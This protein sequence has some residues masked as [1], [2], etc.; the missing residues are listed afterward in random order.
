MASAPTRRKD[1]IRARYSALGARQLQM[2]FTSLCFRAISSGNNDD[3]HVQPTQKRNIRHL[4]NVSRS[5]IKGSSNSRNNFS[6]GVSLKQTQNSGM[7]FRNN[8]SSAGFN[9][10]VQIQR[11]GNGGQKSWHSLVAPR[12]HSKIAL[13][14]S[15][16]NLEH[17]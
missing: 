3:L 10:D 2:L 16:S 14:R 1:P 8:T 7:V 9:A 6:D 17:L 4:S 15:E 12:N 11:P 5:K 13:S